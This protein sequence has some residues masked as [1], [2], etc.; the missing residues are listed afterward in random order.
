MVY[1]W[2]VP[3]LF[4]TIQ[5]PKEKGQTII[6]KTLHRNYRLTCSFF[7]LTFTNGPVNTA[8]IL[9]SKKGHK[10]YC[11]YDWY[12]L[13]LFLYYNVKM[14]L[15]MAPMPSYLILSVLCRVDK[16]EMSFYV[17]IYYVRWTINLNLTKWS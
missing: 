12:C 3:W 17:I 2:S 16:S 4:L 8:C 13:S 9:Y 15:S 10:Y 7:L 1:A 11:N 5:W 6:Y 14:G